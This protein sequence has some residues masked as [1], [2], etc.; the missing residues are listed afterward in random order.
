MGAR[1]K[2]PM[3]TKLRLLS[4]D[5]NKS[6]YNPREPEPREGKLDPPKGLSPAVARVWRER[7]AELEA[8][9]LAYPCDIDSW[10]A[11]CEAV[12]MHERVCAE[13]A[14]APL[15][16]RGDRGLIRNPL[17]L[18]QKDAALTVLRFA[19]AFG[20]TPSARSSVMTGKKNDTQD[21]PFAGTG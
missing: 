3:P 21:N 19:T 7:V 6:R 13:V 14:D 20:L 18:S 10:R 12:V 15:L 11:Y 16:V 2:Q 9:G 4:G 1:G 8:M 17:I 5:P